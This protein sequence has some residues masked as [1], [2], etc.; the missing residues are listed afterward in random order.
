MTPLPGPL[1]RA[2]AAPE[3][4]PLLAPDAEAVPNDEEQMTM[5][6]MHALTPADI[7]RAL[8]GKPS[9]DEG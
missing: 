7:A 8:R 5:V 9:E 2:P 3:Q 4:P 6:Q 1:P